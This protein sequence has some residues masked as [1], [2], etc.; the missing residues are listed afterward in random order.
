MTRHIYIT[1]ISYNYISLIEL[2]FRIY[3]VNAI[4]VLT[5]P[6]VK[7]FSSEITK[8]RHNSQVNASLYWVGPHKMLHFKVGPRSIKFADP[9]YRPYTVFIIIYHIKQ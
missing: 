7:V 2:I 1:D 9:C 6:V 8:Y 3:R 4:H 5:I